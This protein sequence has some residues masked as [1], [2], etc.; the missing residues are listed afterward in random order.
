MHEVEMDFLVSYIGILFF[1][2][3]EMEHIVVLS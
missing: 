3:V 1:I 2:N